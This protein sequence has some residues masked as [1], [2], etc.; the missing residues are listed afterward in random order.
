[1]ADII[2]VR[3]KPGGKM[4]Y[5]R[6]NDEHLLQGTQ[7]IVDTSRG[8]E[9]GEVVM[10]RHVVPDE[11]IT[12]ELRSVVRA[13]TQEDIERVA[14]NRRKEKEA[15]PI[16]ERKIAER[17]LDMKLVSA[18]Y[19]FDGSKI[20]FCFTAD[21]R[22][23]FRELVKDLAGEFHTRIELR[24]IGVRDEAKM[25]GGLGICGRPFCCASFMGD[26]VPVSIKMAKEQG[27]SL[28]PVK[29]SGTCGRLMCCLNH[30]E[31]AYEHLIK[32]TPRQ[33]ARVE[34]SEGKGTVVDVSLL[35]GKLKIRMDKEPESAPLQVHKRH[36][37]VLKGPRDDE[38]IDESFVP[39][40]PYSDIPEKTESELTLGFGSVPL[41]EVSS[42]QPQ[43]STGAGKNGG[44]GQNRQSKGGN[45]RQGQ[46]NKNGGQQNRGNNQQGKNGGG[47]NRG[48]NQQGKGG[49]QQ[50]RGNNQQ[51]KSGGQQ[52]RGN[53]QQGKNGGQNRQN[54]NGQ[55]RQGGNNQQGKNGGQHR[56]NQNGQ[57]RQ[58]G[59]GQQG[60][61]GGHNRPNQNGQHRQGGNGQQGK[62]GGHNRPNNNQP[63]GNNQQGGKPNANA[64]GKGGADGQ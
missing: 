21:G 60:K 25:L 6:P 62:N 61:N 32:H 47:Q 39:E 24:Q 34:T 56:P 49:G 20:L 15:L 16:C 59:N 40:E 18:E 64:P 11:Q 30:E 23:D 48:N 29:I 57:H 27:L 2:G 37:R 12:H 46:Q 31:D 54:Q 41:L 1:M 36:V 43:E 10:E 45:Q 53:N 3:F 22:V 26:F 19:A 58:G 51:G 5:F 52:G 17:G 63:R 44:D 28:N 35:T 38:R 13:A 50:G 9:C 55:H 7:V 8:L 42:V 33:G 14:E 4:Y